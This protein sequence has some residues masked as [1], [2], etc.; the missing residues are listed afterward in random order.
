MSESR[1]LL[2]D[3]D[4]DRAERVATLLEFMDFTPR[5]AAEAADINT[6]KAQ[7][8]DWVA[9]VVGDVHGDTAFDGFIDWLAKAPLHPPLLAIDAPRD[10]A[11]RA[12]VHPDA[13]W[14][15]DFPI[16]RPQLQEALRRAS[17]KRIDEDERRE[18]PP[19]GPTGTSPATV[20]LNRMIDQVAPFDTTVLILGESGTGKEVAA[21]AVHERS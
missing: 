10:A 18:L 21:R 6:T 16:R 5:I 20:R 14:P 12:R 4:M 11:W 7:P 15:L 2:I 17:L 13:V 1:I 9:V 19:G 8:A 3:A